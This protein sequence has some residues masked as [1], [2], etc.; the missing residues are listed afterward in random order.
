MTDDLERRIC[1][2]A[3]SRARRMTLLL[4]PA[5][6]AY[7]VIG[8]LLLRRGAV[9]S[10]AM[11]LAERTQNAIFLALVAAG[12]AC[13]VAAAFLSRRLETAAAPASLSA[14]AQRFVQTHVI[15]IA[16]AEFPAVLGLAYGLLTGDLR[17]M[18]A[19]AAAGMVLVLFFLP[20]RA[21][22]DAFVRRAARPE[23]PLP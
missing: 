22:L 10:L 5:P 1:H 13:I 19:L 8:A 6:A 11:R 14:A 17:R 23:E 2:D 3:W 18:I 21:T 16:L 4:A 12:A 9:S 7:V 20:R 15:V